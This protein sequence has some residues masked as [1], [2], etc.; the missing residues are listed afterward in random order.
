MNCISIEA[1]SGQLSA[2]Q[3]LPCVKRVEYV[4]KGSQQGAPLL[5]DTRSVVDLPFQNPNQL[6]TQTQNALMGVSYMHQANFKGQGV[7]IAVMDGGFVNVDKIMAFRH[8]FDDSRIVAT[9]NF[10]EYQTDVYNYHDHGT[11]VLSCMAAMGEGVVGT[12]PEADYLLLVTEEYKIK[13]LAGSDTEYRIEEY[14]WL[15]CC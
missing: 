2:V 8:L 9:K 10:V 14:N 15:F 7:L 5:D 12:A 4:G 3:A 6:S 11:L 1:D 13:N